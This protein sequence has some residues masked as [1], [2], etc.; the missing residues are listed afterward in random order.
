M[1]SPTA[2]M[3]GSRRCEKLVPPCLPDTRFQ[4]V[5]QRGNCLALAHVAKDRGVA[6]G[7]L[8]H[9][10]FDA[11]DFQR[12]DGFPFLVF[13]GGEVDR[14]SGQVLGLKRIAARNNI[15]RLQLAFNVGSVDWFIDRGM[16]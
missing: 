11:L 14:A 5:G 10:V 12:G 16:G 2:I 15:C 6:K 1:R 13:F 8:Q 3:K 9:I 4:K 7:A